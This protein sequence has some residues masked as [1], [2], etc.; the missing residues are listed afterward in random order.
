[1]NVRSWCKLCPAGRNHIFG[2][3]VFV[4]IVLVVLFGAGHLIGSWS[5]IAQECMLDLLGDVTS[6][7][8]SCQLSGCVCYLTICLHNFSCFAWMHIRHVRYEIMHFGII[9]FLVLFY[10]V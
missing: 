5:L 3:H 7:V 1:M 8:N 6:T 9:F 4:C 10:F 2:I